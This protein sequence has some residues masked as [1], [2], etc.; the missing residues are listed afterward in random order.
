[1]DYNSDGGI[2]RS[3]TAMMREQVATMKANELLEKTISLMSTMDCNRDSGIERSETAELRARGATIRANS[4]LEK[5][6]TPHRAANLENL[7][8]VRR[9]A[10]ENHN[11][12]KKEKR[13]TKKIVNELKKANPHPGIVKK[14]VAEKPLEKMATS[15]RKVNKRAKAMEDPESV[16]KQKCAVL[17]EMERDSQMRA[18]K[19]VDII[20]E[21][22]NEGLR[23]I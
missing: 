18:L 13:E 14:L 21:E 1:M 11:A 23:I 5:T 15:T 17:R 9:A 3:E 8:T 12:Y 20:R 2:D 19:M 4:L 6:I 22:G 7:R 10:E 16:E